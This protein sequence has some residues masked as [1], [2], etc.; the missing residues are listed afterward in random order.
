MLFKNNPGLEV[1]DR[2]I[3]IHAVA[4]PPILGSHSSRVAKGLPMP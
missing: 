1:M 3:P 4:W 2:S